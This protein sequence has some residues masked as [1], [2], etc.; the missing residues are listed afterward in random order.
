MKTWIPISS[1]F[2]LACVMMMPALGLLGLVIGAGC[3]LAILLWG[4]SYL[5]DKTLTPLA[6]LLEAY[7]ARR[8]AN[9]RRLA[10]HAGSGLKRKV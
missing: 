8:A 2:G 7:K 9:R 4:L 1:L 6:A 5:L 3:L 10:V